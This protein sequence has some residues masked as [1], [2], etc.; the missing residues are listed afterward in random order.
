[1][2][3]RDKAA[4]RPVGVIYEDLEADLLAAR[5][6]KLQVAPGEEHLEDIAAL[7]LSHLD[8]GGHLV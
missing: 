7:L 3:D 6:R 4:A 2:P 8:V 1:M 5:R